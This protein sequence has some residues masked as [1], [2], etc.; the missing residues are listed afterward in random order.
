MQFTTKT[1]F[2][3]LDGQTA[4]VSIYVKNVDPKN[5]KMRFLLKK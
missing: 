4:F 2:L 1:Y 5:K 3:Q